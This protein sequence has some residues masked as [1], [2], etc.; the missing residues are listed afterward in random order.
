M[1]DKVQTKFISFNQL[2]FNKN[3]FSFLIEEQCH[4]L[5]EKPII[6]LE[7]EYSDL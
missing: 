2:G 3:R 6:N 5:T 4:S 1:V 7:L